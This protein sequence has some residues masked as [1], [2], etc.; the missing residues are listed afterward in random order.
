MPFTIDTSFGSYGMAA[1]GLNQDSEVSCCIKGQDYDTAL[2][3]AYYAK[4]GTG[5]DG[6][7][8]LDGIHFVVVYVQDMAGLWSV[9]GKMA[10]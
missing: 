8:G 2:G 6:N 3:H 10:I 1:E 9:A 7:N 5:P 4:F